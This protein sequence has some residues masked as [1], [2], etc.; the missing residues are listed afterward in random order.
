MADDQPKFGSS[1]GEAW[2]ND[3]LRAL[4][5]HLAEAKVRTLAELARAMGAEVGLV[6][7]MLE[8]LARGGYVQE[9]HF[10]DADGRTCAGCSQA[11]L[12]RVMHQGRVWALTDKGLRAAASG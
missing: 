5:A 12:C 10:C 6:E 3:P 8:V 4:L 7:Q 2:A 9:T 1:P 11:G